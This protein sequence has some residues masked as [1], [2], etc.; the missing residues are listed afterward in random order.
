MPEQTRTNRGGDRRHAN[1]H[2]QFPAL[3]LGTDKDGATG[4]AAL[5]LTVM[6]QQVSIDVTPAGNPNVVSLK[7]RRLLPVAILSTATFD[8]R[9]MDPTTVTL[10]NWRSSSRCS[11]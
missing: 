11:A 4:S 10:G 7:N 5:T 2:R 8:A 9:D 6:Y 3:H 1:S